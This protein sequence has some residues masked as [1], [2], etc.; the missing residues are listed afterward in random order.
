MEKERTQE[1]QS[2]QGRKEN[3]NENLRKAYD[4]LFG[5]TTR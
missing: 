3:T 1:K 2:A 5:A 4:E